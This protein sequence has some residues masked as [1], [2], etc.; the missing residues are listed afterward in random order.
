M[1]LQPRH[2]NK[3]IQLFANTIQ[4]QLHAHIQIQVQI[5]LQKLIQIQIR[6]K[7]HKYKYNTARP[8][9]TLGAFFMSDSR[10]ADDD[11]DLE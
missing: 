4:I 5:C 6:I 8:P 7:K 2:C 3:A 9:G 1:P 11:E 10:R